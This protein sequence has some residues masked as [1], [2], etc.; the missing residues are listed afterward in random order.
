VS[1]IYEALQ[2][3]EAEKALREQASRD[4]SP[5]ERSTGEARASAQA[6]LDDAWAQPAVLHAPPPA[7]TLPRLAPESWESTALPLEAGQLSALVETVETAAAKAPAV[8]TIDLNSIQSAP[9]NALIQHLPA[10]QDRGRTVEQFRNLRSRMQE[11]R[12]ANRLK[13]ILVTSG[14]PQ[15]GKSF[16]A[17]NLAISLARHK[18]S[19]VLLIDGDMRRSSLHKILGCPSDG[20]GLTEYLSGETTLQQIMQRAAP[21]ADGSPLSHGFASLVFIPAGKE[22]DKAADLSGNHRFQTLIS[23]VTPLF[24]W[25][26]VDSSPVNLVSD[27]VN[28]AR[29]CDG[30]LLIARGEV[31]KFETAQQAVAALEATKLLGFVL[32]AV[33]NSSAPNGYYN[34]DST[35][36]GR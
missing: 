28:L 36:E 8:E 33:N 27:A 10:V 14:L 9:W 12:G 34:Y 2:R 1:R 11:Y 3:A 23:A 13:S 4:Q 7:P 18:I 15:E 25:I 30:V 5:K 16:V 22:A 19:R 26:I 32:N 24:D 17:V 6:T 20:P 31:T 35:A 21:P 29:A